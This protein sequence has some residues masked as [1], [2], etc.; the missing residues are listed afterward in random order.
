MLCIQIMYDSINSHCLDI[1]FKQT[2]SLHLSNVCI[3]IL[4][5]HHLLGANGVGDGPVRGDSP[6]VLGYGFLIY[7]FARTAMDISP[8]GKP[9]G[10]SDVELDSGHSDTKALHRPAM[11]TY[12]VSAFLKVVVILSKLSLPVL[13]YLDGR[14]SRVQRPGSK[15]HPSHTHYQ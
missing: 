11:E 14:S 6:F 5:E 9:I 12:D 13:A 7:L 1:G 10:T 4:L 8:Q 3:C 2:F 15:C